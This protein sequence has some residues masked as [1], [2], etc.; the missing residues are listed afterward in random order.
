MGQRGIKCY[1][2][3]TELA[4]GLPGVL[5]L[6]YTGVLCSLKG[7]RYCKDMPSEKKEP[8]I[9]GGGIS[10]SEI[11]AMLKFTKDQ[12]A[13]VSDE[14]YVLTSSI[15]GKTLNRIEILGLPERQETAVKDSIK[16]LAWDVCN[17]SRKDFGEGMI[18]SPL[19]EPLMPNA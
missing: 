3:G 12:D 14:L 11:K 5:V 9:Y 13:Y 2:W 19:S 1:L 8:Q 10:S 15:I 18:S 7:V 6:C 17:A 16:A 4:T